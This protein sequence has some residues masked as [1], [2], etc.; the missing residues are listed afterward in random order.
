LEGPPTRQ[1]GQLK[2]LPTPPPPANAFSIDLPYDE[3]IDIPADVIPTMGRMHG[4]PPWAFD[5]NWNDKQRAIVEGLPKTPPQPT[6]PRMGYA[7]PPA[8]VIPPSRPSK[9][10]VQRKKAPQS[11]SKPAIIKPTRP[12]TTQRKSMP[13]V[14]KPRKGY[15]APTRPKTAKRAVTPVRRPPSIPKNFGQNIK[16]PWGNITF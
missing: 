6:T 8:S 12:K 15:V 3:P 2:G 14:M 1:Q 10:K 9:P 13:A 11:V 16:T 5:P 4:D 7:A